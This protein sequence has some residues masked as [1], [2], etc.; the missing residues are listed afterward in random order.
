M[1]TNIK[2]LQNIDTIILS[3]EQL[4]KLLLWRD[5]NKDHVRH[6][7]QILDSGIIEIEYSKIYFHEDINANCI[8]YSFFIDN[9]YFVS[10]TFSRITNTIHNWNIN[11]DTNE[12]SKSINAINTLNALSTNK[13]ATNELI[14]DILTT[15]A[16][17]MG[18]MQ[19]Y[20]P[21][22]TEVVMSTKRISKHKQREISRM[23]N[24]N[25][26]SLKQEKIKY[27][28]PSIENIVTKKLTKREI[29]I[30]AWTVRGHNRKLRNGS[31]TFV[32]PYVKGKNKD[33]IKP[34]TYKIEP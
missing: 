30:E 11:T 2:D 13:Q 18:Y 19:Y 20:K 34:K 15:H 16:S 9:V 28:F 31:I 29:T 12:L 3:H 21:S 23:S 33:N 7:R 14:Q 17:I 6:F 32:K 25:T 22:I 1:T 10:F 24:N 5:N 26:L 8:N 4:Q 27:I